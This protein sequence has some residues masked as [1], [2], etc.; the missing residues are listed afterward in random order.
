LFVGSLSEFL[1]NLL[2]LLFE[3]L[4]RICSKQVYF[5]G[6]WFLIYFIL[7]ISVICIVCFEVN[8]HWLIGV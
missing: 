7:F 1:A 5:I 6:F 8:L 2:C 4:F 3:P